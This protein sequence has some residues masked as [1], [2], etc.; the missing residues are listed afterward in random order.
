[1]VA[2]LSG[3]HGVCMLASARYLTLPG[4]AGMAPCDVACFV[5][6]VIFLCVNN[7]RYPILQQCVSILRIT[8]LCVRL[9]S[10]ELTIYVSSSLF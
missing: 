5:N 2:D 8:L 7:V 4:D 9:P 10:L 3:R 1:M 6:P